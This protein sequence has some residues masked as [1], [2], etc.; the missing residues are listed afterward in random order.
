MFSLV[1]M[2]R[3]LGNSKNKNKFVKYLRIYY[4]LGGILVLCN[5]SDMCF[6]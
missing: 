5:I 3:Y 4:Q 1:Q 6:T 2:V